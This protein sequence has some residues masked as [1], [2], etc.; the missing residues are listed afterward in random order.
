MHSCMVTEFLAFQLK[1]ANCKMSG[2][3]HNHGQHSKLR[4][5][6]VSINNIIVDIL[7]RAKSEALINIL[8]NKKNKLCNAKRRRQ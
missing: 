8:I 3:I 1:F 6:S 2:V 7:A 5:V 4:L